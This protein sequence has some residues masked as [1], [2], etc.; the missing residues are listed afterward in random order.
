MGVSRALPDARLKFS[1]APKFNFETKYLLRNSLHRETL[2]QDLG[3]RVSRPRSASS[4]TGV[5]GN[6]FLSCS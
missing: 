5:F 4:E 2:V 1:K 3:A 6:S